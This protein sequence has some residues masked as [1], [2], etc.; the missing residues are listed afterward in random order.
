MVVLAD[1]GRPWS[2]TASFLRQ[3]GACGQ[4]GPGVLLLNPWYR[5]AGHHESL[6]FS[7]SLTFHVVSKRMDGLR[8]L[9]LKSTFWTR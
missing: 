6:R 8:T 2:R 7:S 1:G 5:G 4:G 3:E 9:I